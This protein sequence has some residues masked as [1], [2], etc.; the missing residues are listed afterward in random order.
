MGGPVFGVQVTDSCTRVE[1]NMKRFDPSLNNGVN[2]RLDKLIVSNEAV[3]EKQG[4][5]ITENA[6]AIAVLKAKQ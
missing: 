2:E 1:E 3:N 5:D 4:H 6:K